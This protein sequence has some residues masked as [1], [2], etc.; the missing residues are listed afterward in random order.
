MRT[1]LA[2]YI[3][4]A[5]NSRRLGEAQGR[6][7]V[8]RY[9]SILLASSLFVLFAAP[10]LAADPPS[11]NAWNELED[12][13]SRQSLFK[14]RVIPAKLREEASQPSDSTSTL[15]F[16]KEFNFPDDAQYDVILKKERENSYFGI[17][18]SHHTGPNIQFT[19]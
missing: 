14:D 6:T 18:I 13:P 17:D 11:E 12:D 5:V 10:S 16:P 1:R 19:N 2:R 8:M 9:R 3:S 7:L 4:S 15:A